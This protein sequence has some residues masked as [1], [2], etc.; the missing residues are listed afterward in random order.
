MLDGDLVVPDGGRDGVRGAVVLCHP[1]P[2]Y[3]GSRHDHVLSTLFDELPQ[4]GFAALRFDFRRTFGGAIDERLDARAALD[5]LADVTA[6]RTPGVP[7]HLFGYSFG[8]IVA[9]GVHDARL[10]SHVLLAPPLGAEFP[11]DPPADGAMLVI[12][13][14]HDQFCPPDAVA[15][16]I[17]GWTCAVEIR[18]VTMADHFFAGR[19]HAVTTEVLAHLTEPS[20]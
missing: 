9:L 12:V 1:H 2:Q 8:A 18:T 14:E 16:A 13:A 11:E 15:T 10:A 20:A 7:L 3:G 19:A 17:A 6:E 4:H 5:L